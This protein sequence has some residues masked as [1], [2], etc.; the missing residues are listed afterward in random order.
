MKRIVQRELLDTLSP[1]DPRAVRS[2]QD[3]RRINGWMC[4]H[5]IM[6][7]ALKKIFH[8][9]PPGQ[10]TEIGAGDGT[11]LLRVAQKI[12]PRWP[13]V[14]ATLIDLQ[15]NVSSETLTAFA[16]SGWHAEAVVAD[17]F[18]WP[19]IDSDIVV[20]NLFLH[21]FDG[22]RLTELLQM[23]SRRTEFFIAIEPRRGCWPLFCSRLLWAIGCNDVTRHDAVVSVRAGF[24][25]DE[26]SAL[27]P[28]K[29]NWQLT[30]QRAGAFSHLFIARK[31]V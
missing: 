8:S 22:A 29:Q 30:E 5:V 4:N 16:S 31:K 23:V 12:S 28:D 7:G 27:W 25:G 18:D 26:L 19:K 10:I 6:A 3:L 15:K 20:A 24:S 17:V 11:F 13:D 1:D 9:N 21:H 14:K 2:R